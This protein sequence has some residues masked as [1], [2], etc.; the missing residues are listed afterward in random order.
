MTHS[1]SAG[2]AQNLHRRRSMSVGWA[3]SL[4]FFALLF[5]GR[6]YYFSLVH[7]LSVLRVWIHYLFLQAKKGGSEKIFFLP[8]QSTQYPETYF[9]C[10]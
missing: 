2:P 8:L 9:P 1:D 5:G 4:R 7:A 10:L 3:V 6:S